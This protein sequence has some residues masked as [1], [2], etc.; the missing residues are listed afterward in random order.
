MGSECCDTKPKKGTKNGIIGWI[1]WIN[2]LV[3]NINNIVWDSA[4][5]FFY[6]LVGYLVPMASYRFFF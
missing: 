6:I 2:Y 5:Y 3:S 1:G 4:K